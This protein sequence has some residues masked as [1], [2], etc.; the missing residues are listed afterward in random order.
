MIMSLVGLAVILGLEKLK[1]PGGI[2]L[3]IIGISI[4]GLLFDPNVHFSGIFAMPS[5][6]DENGNS[7]IG[8][9]GY[10]GRVKPCRSAK[11][12]GAGDDGGV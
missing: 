8:S 2:L 7:L 6:S 12:A 1:V 5:L 10:Y 9:F 4:V 3:T 11:R